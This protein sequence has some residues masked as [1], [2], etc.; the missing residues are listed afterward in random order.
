MGARGWGLLTLVT[1]LVG[2][3]AFCGAWMVTRGDRELRALLQSRGVVPLL[4]PPRQDPRRVAL[5]RS[6]FFDR[7]LSGNR[8]IACATCHDPAHGFGDEL[9]LS[10]GTGGTGRGP[11]RR[12]GEGR[13]PIGRHAPSLLNRGSPGWHTFFWDGRVGGR[14]GDFSSKLPL[15]GGLDHLLAAQALFP[16]T[17]RDEMR[18]HP[19]DRDVHGKPNELAS[20]HGEKE[21]AKLWTAIMR[22]LLAIEEYR[23]MF[24]AAYPEVRA[25]QFGIQHVLNALAAYQIDTTNRMDTPFDRYL[26]GD[27]RALQPAARHG[28]SLFYGPAG[29][30]ECHSG[31]LHTDQRFHNLAVPQIGSK[32]NCTNCHGPRH[33]DEAGGVAVGTADF[34]RFVETKKEEDRFG[35]RTPP[36]RNVA[37][38]APYMHD[39]TIDTLEQAVRHHLEP[40]RSLAQRLK[41]LEKEEGIH[42]VFEPARQKIMLQSLDA[43]LSPDRPLTD[44]E[45]ADLVAFLEA[46]TDAGAGGGYDLPERVPSGLPVVDP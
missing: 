17:N 29:C 6:L 34:G 18:G 12:V 13:R 46:L 16:I 41:A 33:A 1:M 19:G 42:L 22:R 35:F 21:S 10:V 31:P 27:D 4:P 43:R 23:G 2:A 26:L 45:V 15:P 25:D 9:R 44:A 36:L 37:L 40:S 24:R 30:Y 3:V 32:G 20:F 7:I 11:E 14:P 8:D 28:A 39:G 5:G 38:T